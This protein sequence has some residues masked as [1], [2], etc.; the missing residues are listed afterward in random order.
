[1]CQAPSQLLEVKV[2]DY[3]IQQRQCGNTG[4]EGSDEGNIASLSLSLSGLTL[5]GATLDLSCCRGCTLSDL[6]LEYPTFNREIVEMNA[7]H[8]NCTPAGT[9]NS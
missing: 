7:P 5:R 3:A 1:M 8:K 2:R 6:A 4:R 9:A